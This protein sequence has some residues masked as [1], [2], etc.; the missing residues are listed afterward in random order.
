MTTADAARCSDVTVEALPGTAKQGSVI[1]AYEQRQGWGHDILD[2][3][4]LG[5][6]TAPIKAM[7]KASGA[8]LLFIRKPGRGGQYRKGHRLYLCFAELGVAEELDVDTPAA[9]LSLDLSGPGRNGARPVDYPL[10]LVCTHGKRD[11]CCAIKGRPLAASLQG[12][13]AGD[14]VWEASHMKGHRFA[15]TLMLLPWGY[16]YGRL[17]FQAASAMM[18]AA[19]E[20]QLFLPGLR[21]RGIYDAPAQVAEIAVAERVTALIGSIAVERAD[22]ASSALPAFRVVAGERAFRVVCEPTKYE[23]V[24]ASCGKPAKCGKGWR[25]VEVT[26]LA[27]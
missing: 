26:E 4:A 16:S 25:A 23:G 21:G 5:E 11:R 18:H 12:C 7:L 20:G 19:E 3:D 13:F 9:M 17:N 1:L 2:G 8:S 27:G 6:D 22:A 10:A 24:V 15:P 14:E